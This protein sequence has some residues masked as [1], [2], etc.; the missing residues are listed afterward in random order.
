M[1][2]NPR[3]LLLFLIPILSCTKDNSSIV[4]TDNITNLPQIFYG[5]TWSIFEVEFDGNRTDVP[6]D[7]NC[8]RDYFQYLESG[9]YI[10]Y[11]HKSSTCIPSI[12]RLNFTLNNGKLLLSDESGGES[13][14]RI[15]KLDET[16]FNFETFLDVDGDKKLD[17][18]K[19]YCQV[20]TPEER[21]IYSNSFEIDYMQ[22]QENVIAFN[23]EE[24]VGGEFKQYEIF[25]ASNS[26]DKNNAIKIATI[27]DLTEAVYVDLDPEPVEELCYF[28]R[29]QTTSG[30]LA[31]SNL[32]TVKT[33]DIY[34]YKTEMLAPQITNGT[35][36][37]NWQRSE[38]P[39]FQKYEI[40][41]SQVASNNS[42]SPDVIVI[43][44]IE[45]QDIT[46]HTIQS[47]PFVEDP[48]YNVHVVNVFGRRGGLNLGDSFTDS[49]VEIS[50]APKGM[51]NM[52]SVQLVTR[53]LLETNFIYIWGEGPNDSYKKIKKFDVVTQ[54]IVAESSEDMN[55]SSEK[56]LKIV[57]SPEGKEILLQIGWGFEVFDAQT[58]DYKYSLKPSDNEYISFND[59]IHFKDDIWLVAD[60]GNEIRTLRR[61]GR[62]MQTIDFIDPDPAITVKDIEE[63]IRIDDTHVLA[64]DTRYNRTFLFE[65]S[66]NG[67]INNFEE[68][69]YTFNDNSRVIEINSS[70]NILLDKENNQIRSLEDYSLITSFENPIYASQLSNDGEYILGTNYNGNSSYDFRDVID[71]QLNILNWKTGGITNISTQGYPQYVYENHEGKL[72]VISSYFKRSSFSRG[73]DKNDLFVEVLDWR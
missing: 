27:T 65:I 42:D 52:K 39:Y 37:L 63:L 58:L 25:R 28:L 7:E 16:N 56:R 30:L 33:S 55:T 38:K 72:V 53:D 23:W 9:Q 44:T 5:K 67:A 47:P 11:L 13:E 43:A 54:E 3:Y 61:T 73:E 15:F 49:S 64:G 26:C 45:D 62:V 32:V 70:S 60:S 29:L 4:D 71:R 50:F 17:K 19:L 46:S 68:I 57:N 59:L 36:Q 48:F 8:G 41:V 31:E 40:T 24:Y 22:Y 10:E 20:Y 14:I 21:D 12:N 66:E 1:K 69:N 2:I 6:D 51:I 34:G 18:V 35:I